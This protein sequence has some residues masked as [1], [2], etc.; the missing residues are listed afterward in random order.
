VKEQEKMKNGI[1]WLASYPKSGNT[2]ARSFAFNLFLDKDKPADINSLNEFCF[3]DGSKNWYEKVGAKSFAEFTDED[4]AALTPKV[5]SAFKN[6]SP[7]PVF[8]KTHV[9]VGAT[10]GVHHITLECTVG[11]V[12]ILRN[13]L[14]VVISFA[15]HFGLDLE[16]S[17][18]VLNSSQSMGKETDHQAKQA[19]GSWSDHVASW[20]QFKTSNM[21]TLRYEDMLDNPEETFGA[22]S[23]FLNVN[24]SKDRLQKAI[25]FSSFDTLKKQEEAKGFKEKSFNNDRFFRVGKA[26]QWKEVLTDAQIDRIVSCH[27]DVMEEF[28]YLPD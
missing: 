16:E 12:Y 17:I 26:G 4:V 18:E 15:D 2:W 7:D 24:P 10:H 11:V 14:D 13:P 1:I 8:V 3:G 6:S 20:Q 19:Y 22:L 21:I 28:G 25:E 27:R 9:A 23:R 5:H